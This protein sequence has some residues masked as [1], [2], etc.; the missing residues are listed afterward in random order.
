MQARLNAAMSRPIESLGQRLR[1]ARER[2]KL[3][4][5]GLAA[6][7]GIKQSDVSK[8]EG[9]R[10]LQTTAI[11]RLAAALRV[12]ALWLEIGDGAEPDWE[13]GGAPQ[14]TIGLL[15]LPPVPEHVMAEAEEKVRAQQA[16]GL[17]QA[18]PIVLDA[19][20]KAPDKARLRTALLALLDDDAPAYRQRV[21][22]LLDPRSMPEPPKPDLARHRL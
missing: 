17:S 16:T 12:P 21:A 7:A 22:E 8:I 19:I 9:G 3:T 14:T 6:A 13:R 5:A 10:I 15:N 20:A 4:Q 1:L 18:L 11:A 2:R